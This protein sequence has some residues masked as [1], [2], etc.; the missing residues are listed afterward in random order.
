MAPSGKLTRKSL[1]AAK[2]SRNDVI[3]SPFLVLFDAKRSNEDCEHKTQNNI[4]G[5]AAH[6]THPQTHA[7]RACKA[8]SLKIASAK[9]RT[10][11]AALPLTKHTHKHM[12]YSGMPLMEKQSLNTVLR[13]VRSSFKTAATAINTNL[14][15][16]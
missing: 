12:Q 16:F 11:S 6:K 13:H 9:H 7:H 4:S 3:E 15:D 5:I 14:S 10:T 1:V 8:L 2:Y